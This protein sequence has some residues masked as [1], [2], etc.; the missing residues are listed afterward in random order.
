MLVVASLGAVGRVGS[1]R[2]TSGSVATGER[3]EP[4]LRTGLKH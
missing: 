4:T 2:S 1:F 3:R